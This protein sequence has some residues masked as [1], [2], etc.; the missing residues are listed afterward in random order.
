MRSALRDSRAEAKHFQ[1]FLRLESQITPIFKAF[2]T[3]TG[4]GAAAGA[5]I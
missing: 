4:S 5:R 1:A 3:A 2:L